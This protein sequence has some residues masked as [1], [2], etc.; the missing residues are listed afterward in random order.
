MVIVDYKT[1]L[2]NPKYQ[3]QLQ[4]YQDILEEMGFKVSQKILL[5]INKD[6]T[7]KTYN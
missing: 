5:F 3:H 7:I 6:V 1:G 2:H 4:D